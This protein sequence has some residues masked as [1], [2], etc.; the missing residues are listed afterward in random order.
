M[1]TWSRSRLTPRSTTDDRPNRGRS[2]AANSRDPGGVERIF[3]PDSMPTIRFPAPL[4]NDLRV[5]VRA[6]RH[7]PGFTIAA[8]LTLALGIGATTVIFG[9]VDAAL[10]R[11]LP[12]HE[13][14]RLVAVFETMPG[15][16][17]RRVAPANFLDWQREIRSLTALAGFYTSLRTIG[18]SDVPERV[19]STS[20]S[21]GIFTTLGARAAHGRT[22]LAADDSVPGERLVVLS[23]GLWRRKFGADQDLV[24]KAVRIDD[25]PYTVIGIMPAGFRFPEPTELWTLGMSGVPA[26]GGAGP[27]ITSM[28]DVHYFNVI[29]RL[30]PGASREATLRELSAI[31]AGI[32]RTHPDT[33]RDLGVAIVGL[34]EALAG[35]TRST[36]LFLFAVVGLVLLMA[37]DDGRAAPVAVINEAAARQYWPDSDPI[38]RRIGFGGPGEPTWRIIVGIIGNVRHLGLDQPVLPEVFVP[39]LQDPDRNMSIVARTSID[40]ASVAEALRRA[41]QEVDVSQA[42][43][44]PRLMTRQLAGSLARPRFLSALLASFAAAAL[45]LATLGVYG[46]VATVAQARTRELGIRVALGAQRSDVLRLVL[47]GGARLAGAGLALGMAGAFWFA[48]GVRGLLVGVEPTDPVVFVVTA[49]LLGTAALLASWLPARRAARTD[50][51]IALR[52]E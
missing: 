47:S 48:R 37:S 17:R 42:L 5:G 18:G 13:P 14:D 45:L 30:R 26:L 39:L 7:A 19:L 23:D 32:E 10:L 3:S 12:Y 36:L 43:M 15:N 8:V 24:G 20:V 29:G 22:F 6:L 41:L 21:G 31:A 38:G 27:N 50:P 35:D 44:T 1:S 46:V 52:A 40:P 28:R 11:P 9:V 2:A 33:N 34:R 49:S 51:V 4:V 25:Q 16:E